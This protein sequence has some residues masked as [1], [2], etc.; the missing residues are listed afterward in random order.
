MHTYVVA[1]YVDGERYE[2]TLIESEISAEKRQYM[3]IGFR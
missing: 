3:P 1:W 2:A